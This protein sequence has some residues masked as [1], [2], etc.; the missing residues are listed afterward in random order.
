MRGAWSAAFALGIGLG[1]PGCSSSD[2]CS[3]QSSIDQGVAAGQ[4]TARAALDALLSSRPKWLDQD[5]WGIGSTATSPD[6]SVTFVAGSDRVVVF[7]SGQN[8]R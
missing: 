4:P 5:G 7:R 1:L 2:A 8:G 6:E 3:G